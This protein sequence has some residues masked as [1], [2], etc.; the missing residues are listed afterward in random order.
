MLIEHLFESCKE[1]I[2]N[3]LK[4]VLFQ[5]HKI[6]TKLKLHGLNLM[7]SYL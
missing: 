5:K 1:I 3:Y 6:W 7:I 2:I 4:I